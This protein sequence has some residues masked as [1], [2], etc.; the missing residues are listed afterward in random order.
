MPALAAAISR[1]VGMAR[2]PFKHR[3]GQAAR[4][5]RVMEPQALEFLRHAFHQMNRGMVLLWRLGLG[6]MAG[7]WPK[8]FGRLL[9][10]EHI[11][12]R[13]G[14]RYLT[15]INYTTVGGHLYCVAAFGERTDWYRNLLAAPN[16]AVWLPN[17]R[18]EASVAD[19]SDDP[20]R[21]DLMRSVLIDSGFAAHLFGLHPHHINDDDLAEATATYR[22]LRIRPLRRQPA[23]NGPGDLTWIWFPVL[24]TAVAAGVLRRRSKPYQ[25]DRAAQET[26][27]RPARMKAHPSQP[28]HGGD[29]LAGH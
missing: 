18:W 13:S 15:P 10:I 5:R 3:P 25:A 11:G 14:T 27:E 24:G 28:I 2:P 1:L 17:G 4:Y 22:L 6:R 9:V 23:P 12:R 19:V 21:L 26:V 20:R 7:V 8:G 16:T 29:V